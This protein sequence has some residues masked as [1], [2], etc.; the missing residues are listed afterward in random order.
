MPGTQQSYPLRF[1]DQS[2]P[3]KM[4]K[5]T[6]QK[7]ITQRQNM[8]D[9]EWHRP[10]R[11]RDGKLWQI[12]GFRFSSDETSS[13]RNEKWRKRRKRWRQKKRRKGTEEGAK[14][15]MMRRRGRKGRE[16]KEREE[17]KE[18]VVGE[19]KE[20][21]LKGKSVRKARMIECTGEKNN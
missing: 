21:E 9:A 5:A 1:K 18:T 10:I 12:L 2:N 6:N 15:K 17:G 8:G 13:K 4:T 11:K 16:R 3:R 7:E 20:G 14:A 19:R